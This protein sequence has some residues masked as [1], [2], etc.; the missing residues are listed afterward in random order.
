MTILHLSSPQRCFLRHR[1]G[2]HSTRLDIHPP[3]FLPPSSN[4]V[5]G[6]CTTNRPWMPPLRSPL[7]LLFLPLPPWSRSGPCR[8]SSRPSTLPPLPP[9]VLLHK[10]DTPPD[11]LFS[12]PSV[13]P[14]QSPLPLHSFR[15]LWRGPSCSCFSRNSDRCRRWQPVGWVATSLLHGFDQ[16]GPRGRAA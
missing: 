6:T 16:R 2:R 11:S 8:L 14:S 1:M 13:P 3:S 4:T 7:L 15:L 5:K 9:P 10:D 12:F